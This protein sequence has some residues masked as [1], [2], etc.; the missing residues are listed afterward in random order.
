M[1]EGLL[2]HLAFGFGQP[3][4]LEL[5]GTN[6]L[7]GS[8]FL[9]GL[10][11]LDSQRIPEILQQK[12]VLVLPVE[13]ANLAAAAKVITQRP[14]LPEFDPLIRGDSDLLL[15]FTGDGLLERFAAINATLRKLPSAV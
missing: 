5:L 1:G 6:P 3:R 7:E 8:E 4:Q 14:D 13:T 11:Y 12:E 9:V 2:I 10:T 15:Q